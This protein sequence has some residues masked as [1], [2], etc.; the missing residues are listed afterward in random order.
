MLGPQHP[1]V[2]TSLNS[3]AVLYSAQGRYEAAEPLLER[4][5]AI[6]EVVL[7]AQ[8]PQVAVVLENYAALLQVMNGNE[9]ARDVRSPC[10]DDTDQPHLILFRLGQVLP[11]LACHQ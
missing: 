3:L 11:Y 5:L 4:A 1:D 10:S 8:H 7:G 2:A 9:K 6:S